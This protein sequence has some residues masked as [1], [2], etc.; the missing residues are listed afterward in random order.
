MLPLLANIADIRDELKGLIENNL[1]DHGASM[2][3]GVG[4]GAADLWFTVGGVEYVLTIK[5]TGKVTKL[6]DPA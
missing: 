6:K 3:T 5:P 1:S 4:L 2:D